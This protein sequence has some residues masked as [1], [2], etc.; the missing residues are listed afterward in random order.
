MAKPPPMGHNGFTFDS[1]ADIPRDVAR[2]HFFK[3]SIQDVLDDILRMPKEERGVYMTALLVMYKEM[4]GLPADDK[5]AAMSLGLD[6]RE[7]RHMK[8]KLIA[9]GLL[10]ERPS[11]R[12][13]NRRFEAEICEYVTMFK[14][15]QQA[16]TEREMKKRSEA[17]SPGDRR[18][19]ADRSPTDR[20]DLA[21]MSAAIPAQT[22]EDFSEKLNKNNGATTTREPQAEHKAP[23]RARVLELEL[24]LEREGRTTNQ[25]IKEDSRARCATPDE[26]GPDE[27]SIS[28]KVAMAARL[29]ARLIGSDLHP[30]HDRG[31]RLAQQWAIATSVD[32]VLDG[33]MDLDARRRDRS[34]PRMVT[35]RIVGQYVRQA[36]RNRLARP[37]APVERPPPAKIQPGPVCDGIEISESGRIIA[38]NGVKAQWLDD[39]GGDEKMLTVALD[40]VAA[41]LKPNS[42]T[43]I[44]MQIRGRVARIRREMIQRDQSY[45]KAVKDR[46]AKERAPKSV[47]PDGGVA[48]TPAQRMA[49]LA[50]EVRLEEMQ[51]GRRP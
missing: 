14:N 51:G 35:D 29:I 33:V 27:G 30:D 40:E 28:P 36:E 3:C 41:D 9:R 39:F 20:R 7:W 22:D 31:L 48:E 8:P 45:Q 1:R 10:Y 47:G 38:S 21:P 18:E 6:V 13:S 4:E 34:E 44:E 49:R 37:A 24:E 11:G 23:T 25:S 2:L 5:M 46:A 19:I 15:R 43:S 32:D 16:A 17:R 12:I 50:A 26:V 42:P